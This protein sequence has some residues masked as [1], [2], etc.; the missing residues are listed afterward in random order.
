MKVQYRKRF[1]TDLAKIPARE[2]K[3]IEKFAFEDFPALK[4]VAESGK[5]ERLKGSRNCYKV[6]FGSYRIGL[7][8]DEDTASFERALHRSE[9]Y[10]FFP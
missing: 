2:R 3:A 7:K 4:S 6:R 10:R 1:L 8:L 9:I 5:I